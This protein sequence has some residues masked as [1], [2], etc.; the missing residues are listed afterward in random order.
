MS[1]KLRKVP[2]KDLYWVVD[3][4]GKKYSKEGLPKERAQAQIKALYVHTKDEIK[5]GVNRLGISGLKTTT[6]GMPQEVIQTLPPDNYE[7]QYQRY[8]DI[9]DWFV[10]NDPVF[11]QS[12]ENKRKE[13]MKPQD[14]G[15]VREAA[16]FDVSKLFNFDTKEIK[17]FPFPVE[18]TPA[19]KDMYNQLSANLDKQPSFLEK[20]AEELRRKK[21]EYENN[22]F[23]KI[24][25]GLTTI[26][27]VAVGVGIIPKPLAE[28]Y[29]TFAPPTSSYYGGGTHKE[30][31][32]K[33]YKLKDKPYS[34]K[35]LSKISKVPED[36]LQEVYNRG[37]G[38]H[39]S[40]KKSVRLKGSYVKNVDAPMKYK[41]SKEQWG[42]A[43]VYSFLTGNPKHDEDLRRNLEGGGF[44]DTLK[45]YTGKVVNEFVNPESVLRKRVSDVSKGI[46]KDKYPPSARRTI[47]KYKDWIIDE[48]TIRRDPIQ[49]FINTAF[50]LL[51]LGKWDEVKKKYNY[52]KLFHL[53]LVLN[54]RNPNTG[55]VVP[56]IAEKN[57]V[58]NISPAKKMDKD[59][60]TF[61]L[62]KP[63]LEITLG[64][65]LANAEQNMPNYFLYDAFVNNCQ[66]YILGLLKFSD[67]L[68]EP[69]RVFIKQPVDKLLVDLPSYIKP[70]AKR[71]TDLGG[72]TNVV[73]EGE[74]KK[75]SEKKSLKFEKQL[76][77]IGMT[78]NEYLHIA[79]RRAEI[80]GYNPNDL[81]LAY[82]GI[83]KLV[84]KDEKNKIHEFGRV[85][86]GDFIIWS[87]L[88]KKGDVPKGT[89]LSKQKRFK[90]SHS[91]IK[92]DWKSDKYSPNNLALNINW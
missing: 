26:A 88:E 92:G 63:Q 10:E 17:R 41:L 50:N 61:K 56:I 77:K 9:Y 72:L 48:L 66:D 68:T 85:G 71:I 33:A 29:K 73:L 15:L 28:V 6:E 14:E 2:K 27:D 38:A 43:R 34:I 70:V 32:L 13:R 75:K 16:A 24:L 54:L 12:E 4:S 82:D 74:G 60:Q 31:F 23:T 45:E 62:P 36:I 55:E 18:M 21:E 59:T 46:R 40:S 90:A 65:L 67:L 25:K 8:R 84:M 52:D 20:Q 3:T 81:L 7:N 64:T 79:K 30:D 22:P 42:M 83:H 69:A 58:I 39:S 76:E 78:P 91:K 37:V 47:T 19:Q 89:A 51:T 5:G 53:G 80:A 35:E 57:E 87:H 49:S 44:W 1:Y 11:R 86:Y